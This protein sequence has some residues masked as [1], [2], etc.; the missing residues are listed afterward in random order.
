MSMEVISGITRRTV[1]EQ[2]R[3]NK[4]PMRVSPTMLS[5]WERSP[6]DWIRTYI[7]VPMDGPDGKRVL[8]RRRDPQNEP[9]AAGSAFDAYIKY[10]LHKLQGTAEPGIPIT[11]TQD[12]KVSNG[13]CP[14][15][16]RALPA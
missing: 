13:R 11:E 7:G 10:E 4:G 9:M 2:E 3:A 1:M 5:T 14:D 12:W 16:E 15:G 6:I 8:D